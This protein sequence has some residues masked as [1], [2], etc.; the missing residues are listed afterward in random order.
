MPMTTQNVGELLKSAVERRDAETLLSLYD[1]NAQL[2]VIDRDHP[3]SSPMELR[4]KQAIGN[5]QRE[6]FKREMAHHIDTEV[7]GDGHLAFS[8][9]CQY[10]DGTRVYLQST[11]EVKNGKI[12]REVDVQAWDEH[13]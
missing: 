6:V 12:V 4:G 8:E 2:R 3:P 13:K 9:S 10:A 5:Y 7:V 1:D 11:C